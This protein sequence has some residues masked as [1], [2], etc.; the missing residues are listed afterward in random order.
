VAHS[1]KRNLL[2]VAGAFNARRQLTW[3]IAI[4]NYL[5]LRQIISLHRCAQFDNNFPSTPNFRSI[6]SGHQGVDPRRREMKKSRGGMADLGL[7]VAAVDIEC[8]EGRDRHHLR[9]SRGCHGHEDNHEDQHSACAEH[10]SS[11]LN[12]CRGQSKKASLS[13][14]FIIEHV[15]E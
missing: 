11:T 3:N 6:H 15:R 10:T 7:H 4:L 14:F 9:R 8:E 13:V 5:H 1:I 12:P 2:G